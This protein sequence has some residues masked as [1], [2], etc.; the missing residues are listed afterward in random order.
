MICC[1]MKM[2]GHDTG[3]ALVIDDG[4]S[5]KIRA[6]S[7]ERARREKHTMKFPIISLYTILE[8]EKL[9]IDDIDVFVTN[10]RRNVFNFDEY[11][12][13]NKEH[14]R[15][16]DAYIGSRIDWN[17]RVHLANH[18]D[19]HASSAYYSSPFEEATVVVIDASGNCGET[20]SIYRARGLNL[21]LMER[22]FLPG[23]GKLYEKVTEQILGL[24]GIGSAGKTMGL[25]PFGSKHG[26][27][28][29]S[30][31][32]RGIPK[33]INIVYDGMGDYENDF[34]LCFPYIQCKNKQELTNP[35][36]SRIAY[37]LQK[38]TE[39]QIVR[40]VNYAYERYPSDNLC[41]AGGVALNC[42]ANR[43]IQEQTSFKRIWIQPAADDSGIAL[44]AALWGYYNV[45][46]QVKR[47]IMEMPYL[48]VSY[49]AV[50]I[51]SIFSQYGLKRKKVPLR[52]IAKELANGKVIGWYDAESEF[53][54]RALGHRSILS[55]ARDVAFRERLNREIKHREP[56]RPVAPIVLE[57]DSKDYFEDVRDGRHMLYAYKVKE[58][59]KNKI[60]AVVHVDETARVQTINRDTLPVLHEL[61]EIY[62][63]IT[64]I[65]VLINTSL[66]DNTEAI[67]ETPLDAL[68]CA[69]RIKL[70]GLYIQGYYFTADDL[71]DINLEKMVQ[72]REEMI[73]EKRRRA[74]KKY[75]RK[76][77]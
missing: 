72:N 16:F 3:C 52:I 11:W 50:E 34:K 58:N 23:I 68:I 4:E 65:P 53:G 38:E 41:Y 9:S 70:D 48:G 74:G 45:M 14:Y 31:W 12:K 5:I 13:F 20:Q 76:Q 69:C 67:V 62:R 32:L 43:C 59:V 46:H 1:G 21:E 25:A 44:G 8:A 19:L 24:P 6:L 71:S 18:H 47:Y 73:M 51:E 77:F 40:L 49:K 75:G 26:E 28:S 61:L 42:S 15:L 2:I 37:D 33:G 35:Y 39:E 57:E 17:Q 55:D 54:P 10:H 30:N 7:E 63:E 64:G 36:Y 66:N 56:F 29:V 22:S 27:N 60:P